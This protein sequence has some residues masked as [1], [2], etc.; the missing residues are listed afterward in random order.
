VAEGTIKPKD[1]IIHYFEKKE[2]GSKVTQIETDKKGYL[3]K[4]L[5]G[6]F[7]EDF[8]EALAR[9]RAAMKIGGKSSADSSEA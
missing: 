5:P 2:S 3:T 4:Q 7:E 8:E 1:T 9:L 6:F